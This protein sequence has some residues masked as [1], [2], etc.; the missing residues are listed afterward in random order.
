MHNAGALQLNEFSVRIGLFVAALFLNEYHRAVVIKVF[1]DQTL[2]V[3]TFI[4]V[5]LIY[6]FKYKYFIGILRRLW[7]SR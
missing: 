7:Y 3:I 1:N 6:I 4:N 5:H 2:K